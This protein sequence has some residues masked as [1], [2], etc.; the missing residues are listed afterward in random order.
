VA[1]GE[2]ATVRESGRTRA[3]RAV[4]E[5]IESSLKGRYAVDAQDCEP[6][7]V[8]PAMREWLLDAGEE[9]AALVAGGATLL[10]L[11]TPADLGPWTHQQLDAFCSRLAPLVG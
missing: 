2:G 9:G 10:A 11:D 5:E 3:A 4:S 1:V 8:T 7:F 6:G